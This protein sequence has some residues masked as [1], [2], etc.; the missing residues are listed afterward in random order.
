MEMFDLGAILALGGGGV[1]AGWLVATVTQ[2][3]KNALPETWQNGR[4][5]LL[6]VYV[7]SGLL[8]YV[9]ITAAPAESVPA[10]MGSL[11]VLGLLVWQGITQS[12]IGANQLARKVQHVAAG[13]TDPRGA[14]PE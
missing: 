5:I 4:G 13:T 14:D 10:D 11:L 2:L 1:A 9:A 8:T 12:A 6:V 7:Q 3:I